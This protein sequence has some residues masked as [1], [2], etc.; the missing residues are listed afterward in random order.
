MRKSGHRV[1]EWCGEHRIPVSTY[2]SRQRKAFQAA[3]S[4]NEV[5]FTEIPV[6]PAAA[7]M[8][9]P[10]QCGELWVDIHARAD[11]ETIRAIIQALKSC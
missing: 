3:V 9:T 6:G 7:E 10:V 11:T 8:A 5:C 2:D 4:E 1:S